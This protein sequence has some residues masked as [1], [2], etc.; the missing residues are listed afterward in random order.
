MVQKVEEIQKMN[1]GKQKRHRKNG[2]KRTLVTDNCKPTFDE[3][4]ELIMDYCNQ[5][6][7][8]KTDSFLHKPCVSKQHDN[9]HL[10]IFS[11]LYKVMKILEIPP[12]QSTHEGVENR[13]KQVILYRL[14]RE[15]SFGDDAYE[16]GEF[17]QQ[18][19]ET[20]AVDIRNSYCVVDHKPKTPA[21]KKGNKP[22]RVQ[23][24]LFYFIT[25][26][27]AE[28][29]N[30]VRLMVAFSEPK[31]MR[32]LVLNQFPQLLEMQRDDLTEDQ[33]FER[34]EARQRMVRKEKSMDAFDPEKMA[35]RKRLCEESN[36]TQDL[37]KSQKSM[38]HFTFTSKSTPKQASVRSL[39]PVSA[40][41]LTFALAGS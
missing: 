16:F 5:L 11:F 28:A 29:E 31:K 32:D 21:E 15:V 24:V 13:G 9:R 4:N 10:R 27:K 38:Y 36:W 30:L 23:G 1:S 7:F 8:L 34:S 26:S 3:I 12:A 35:I 37:V 40:K 19:M 22:R 14:K 25:S 41:D 39:S 33:D 20:Q 2:S 6:D 17:L 18:I